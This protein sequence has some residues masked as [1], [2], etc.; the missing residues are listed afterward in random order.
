[1]LTELEDLPEG[2]V[3]FETSGKIRAED[4]RDVVLPVLER[5]A[6]ADVRFVVVMAD[7]DGMSG[8][9]VWEDLKVAIEQEVEAD[10]R[11]ERRRLGG[12]RHRPLRLG[13]PGPGE[14]VPARRA[15][16]G[17]RVGGRLTGHRRGA[18]SGP[19]GDGQRL[20]RRGAH[21]PREIAAWAA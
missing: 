2:V 21:P 19:R 16:G 14:G 18:S 13:D 3:G 5:A 12:P 1:M 20:G 6:A 9:A 15:P 11:G 17:R 7:F 8:G 10:R 4:Y